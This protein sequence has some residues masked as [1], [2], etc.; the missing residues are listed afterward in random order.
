MRRLSLYCAALACALASQAAAGPQFHLAKSPSGIAFYYLARPNDAKA[1]L[2]FGWRDGF[3]AAEPGMDGLRQLGPEAM[4]LGPKSMSE[5]EMIETLNDLHADAELSSDL[6]YTSGS[7]EAPPDRLEAAMTLLT[8][9]FVEPGLREK[10][11]ARLKKQLRENVRESE[12]RGESL[13]L[14]VAAAAGFAD[15]P[16][17]RGLGEAIYDDITREDIE[18]WRQRVFARDNLTIAAS[19]PLDEAAFGLIVDR[20]FG[21]LPEKSRLDPPHWPEIAIKPRT[22]VFEK[23]VPQTIVVIV[24][25]T[26]VKAG[27]EVSKDNIAN[28]TLGAGSSS[29]LSE[30][31][32]AKLGA[33]Y[34]VSS[35]IVMLQPDQRVLAISTALSPDRAVPAI[36][37]MHQ[38]YA[39]WRRDGVSEEEFAPNR[40]R[41]LNQFEANLDRPGAAAKSLID[42]A[43]VGLEKQAA[44]MLANLD[45]KVGGY[46]LADVNAAI[47][48]KFPEPPLLTVIVAPNADG[49][50]ADCVI[51]AISEAK[52]CK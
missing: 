40:A 52:N 36:A 50:S 28:M 15:H 10:G 31:I 44:D 17:S 12:A 13:A 22:I 24:G 48:Q 46:T 19:G 32:R 3:A 14:R 30:A 33:T 2:A 39:D 6:V 38:V 5:G 26:G 42:F 45:E 8:S 21:A 20:A 35:R 34:G 25:A 47:A 49:Y 27:L 16:Y 11:L 7:L 43:S 29:R 4:L 41:Y 1:V 37:A 9:A 23:D 18:T 51:H